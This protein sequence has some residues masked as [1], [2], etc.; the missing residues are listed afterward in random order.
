M[1][2]SRRQKALFWALLALI[3]GL[4]PLVARLWLERNGA[5]EQPGLGVVGEFV[6]RDELDGVLTRDQLR[7][8]TTVVIHWPSACRGANQCV[9]ARQNLEQLRAWVEGSLVPK[10]SEENNPLLLVIVGDG[11]SDL[12]SFK[13]WK[14]FNEKVDGGTILPVG[15]DINK[16]W[17]TVVDNV[18]Q[19][20]ALQNLE[21]SVDIVR[22]ERVISKSSFDQYLGNYLSRRTF[23]GPRRTHN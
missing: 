11:A 8:S 17:L 23:M 9:L 13:G 10:W 15:S 4:V 16:P 20:A 14:R 22:L 12:S 18:L 6:F 1:F 19:F 2:K 5:I 7:R 3:I 21:S